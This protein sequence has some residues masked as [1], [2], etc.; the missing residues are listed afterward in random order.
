[1][2]LDKNKI[3][4]ILGILVSLVCM[5][6][7]A[8]KIEWNHLNRALRE[9]NYIY[10]L[11]AIIITLI[12]FFIR[13]IRWSI[14]I[15]PVKKVSILNLFSANMIGFMANN[16]LPAR[17]GEV[18]RPI[19]IGKKE[20]IKLTTSIATVVMER[21]F[22]ILS[23][24]TVASVILFVIPTDNIHKQQNNSNNPKV[25]I[26]EL[27]THDLNDSHVTKSSTSDK[28][29]TTGSYI[30][31]QLKKW[32]IIFAI[33]GTLA[34][35]SLFLLSI[36][37]EKASN[38]LKKLSFFLPHHIKDKL[39]SFLDSFIAGL[40]ILDNKKQLLWIGFLSIIIWLLNAAGIYVLSYSFNIS[41]SFVAACFINICI[42]IAVALPQ[43]PGFIGVFH[44]AVQKSLDIFGVGLSSSQS[45]AII[46]WAISVIP[47]TLIGLMFLWREGISLREITKQS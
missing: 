15:S 5:W 14:L 19:M 1:M 21:I 36:Y 12:S 31:K 30:I 38:I 6:L 17:V 33:L 7:F 44:I 3:I 4:F 32:S 2:K 16:V 40:Q 18:I 25:S 9:A 24:I 11:P 47:V 43:A 35:T 41:L 8:R 45:Y 13:T 42:A 37:P 23:I 29:R 27:K 26:K 34:I 22:D 39:I 28:V 20:N 46:L 10:V